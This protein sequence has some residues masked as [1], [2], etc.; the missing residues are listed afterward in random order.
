[1]QCLIL[2][3]EKPC[4]QLPQVIATEEQCSQ[5]RN[6]INYSLYDMMEAHLTFSVT[7]FGIK[8]KLLNWLKKNYLMTTNWKRSDINSHTVTITPPPCVCVLNTGSQRRDTG[9]HMFS[10]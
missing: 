8:G 7:T 6:E 1:M 3:A 2:I 9:V 10:G 4:I 5:M